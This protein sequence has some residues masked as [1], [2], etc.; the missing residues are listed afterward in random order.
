VT[1][2]SWNVNA[3]GDW[4][5]VAN[6]SLARLPDS[7]DAVLISTADVQSVTHNSGS[8]IIDRLV[9]GQDFFSL[10]GGSLNILTTATFA[11]GYTQ[12]GG[13]LTV[14]VIAI[15]GAAKLL[16]GGSEGA[17]SFTV[18]GTTTLS[19]YT[20]G[21]ASLFTVNTTANETGQVALG[22]STDVG[23]AIKTV[24][25]GVYSIAGD[26]GI[27][28][29]ASS[30]SFTNAGTL[31]K[32]SGSGTSAIGVSVTSTGTIAAASGDLQFNGPTNTITGTLSGAGEISFGAGVTA[33][34]ATSITAATLGIGNAA[35]VNLQDDLTYSGTFLD[36][37][38]GTSTLNLGARNL[39]LAGASAT[40]TGDFGSA[41]VT[42]SGVLTNRSVMTLSAVDFGGTVQVSNDKTI[43]QTGQVT[44]GDGSGNAPSITNVSGAVYDFTD[45]AALGEDNT[46][47]TFLNEGT[48][49]KS[50]GVA[51]QNSAISVAVTNSGT[52]DAAVGALNFE[53]A[54]ANTGKIIGAGTVEVTGVGSLTLN[55]GSALSVANFDLLD[56]ADLTL[57]TSLT[58]AGVFDDTSD[59]SDEINLGANTLTL[60]GAT[61]TLQGDFGVTDITGSGILENAREF[62]L[63][64]AVVDGT[65]TIDNVGDI[66]Q[67]GTVQIGGSGGEVASIVNAA[68]HFYVVAGA[69]TLDNGAA[70]ASDFNN[71]GSVEVEA[72]T[73]TATFA[74][75]FNNL[76]GG[77]LEVATG[78][79][80]STAT[81][82][83]DATIS[84]TQLILGEAGQTTLNAGSVLSVRQIDIND[85]AVLTLGTSLTYA[86]DFIDASNGN[87]E[88]NL[89]AATLTLS[90]QSEFDSSF[91]SDVV[92]G[93]GAMDLTHASLLEGQA[94]LIGGTATLN[95]ENTLTV[96]GALQIGDTSANAAKAVI[97][98][99]GIYD[100]VA[101]VGIARGSSAASTLTNSGLF[102][103]TA[104][105][106]TSEVSVDFVNDGT[107]TVTSGTL[108]FL[109][110]TLT[111]NGTINGTISFD[112]SGDELIT[113]E[114]AAVGTA[115]V[116]KNAVSESAVTE[117]TN[118]APAPSSA[119]ALSLMVQAA[120]AFGVDQGT[121]ALPDFG[122]GALQGTS[123]GLL[124]A[125]QAGARHLN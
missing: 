3:G 26:F 89:G 9:V 35:T 120:A 17:A 104:G 6:W 55:A 95:I 7:G 79:L 107:I 81:L 10:G 71:S 34:G 122:A 70:T 123:L 28:G 106:G 105:T 97:T 46:T 57:G 1:I 11:D 45:D 115:V 90:G 60:T 14:G 75:T 114:T 20:F 41:D 61:N 32:T 108:E 69:F 51:G 18:T 43:D 2:N 118:K 33:L 22:D 48:L 12:T 93:T 98:A 29:G 21:G 110:G 94:L 125:N 78:A 50:G 8:D 91:G 102:E 72:G 103:K 80:D 16:G 68:G 65:A 42:G 92:T 111:N 4:A 67:N 87:D 77:V 73:G 19:N 63:G 117:A 49:E 82:I 86:G 76:T 27:T 40:I 116:K 101:D 52:I 56:T 121:M 96:S 85:T 124:G 112:S 39:E 64:G 84:G 5:T 44:V 83:N 62:T 119:A 47:A 109:K 36:E 59:G 30:A 74:T 58:Y 25:G 31:Q 24:A 88:I 23:A 15:T 54:V 66:I 38:D 37:S 100:L 53:G 113:A 13:T 99:A